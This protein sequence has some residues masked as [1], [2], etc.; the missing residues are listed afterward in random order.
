[1]IYYNFVIKIRANS[2]GRLTK[3]IIKYINK[4]MKTIINTKG[5][6]ENA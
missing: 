1:M 2:F 4:V 3:E 6:K 5:R